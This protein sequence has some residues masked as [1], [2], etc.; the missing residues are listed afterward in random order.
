LASGEREHIDQA[1]RAQERVYHRG[2]QPREFQPGEKVLLLIPTTE[3]KFLATWHGPYD[4]V[5][6]VGDVNYKV[7][8]PG[9]RKPLQLYHVNLLKTCH[10]HTR[11]CA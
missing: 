8:Q 4:I 10:T 9:R 1:Q 7:R 5:E 11:H 2:A 6:S 3:S